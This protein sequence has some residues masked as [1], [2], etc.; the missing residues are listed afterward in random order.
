MRTT[1]PARQHV[2]KAK[3]HLHTVHPGWQEQERKNICDGVILQEESAYQSTK[4]GVF[5]KLHPQI[6]M[7]VLVYTPAFVSVI[8]T[9]EG[10]CSVVNMFDKFFIGLDS[11][12]AKLL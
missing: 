5:C 9:D 12:S 1:V 6:R 3:G 10:S 4:I 7:Y 8:I 11:V 2:T